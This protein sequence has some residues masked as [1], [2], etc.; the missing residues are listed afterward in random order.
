V[1]IAMPDAADTDFNDLLM[2]RRL[3]READHG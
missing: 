2:R 3:A 1:R